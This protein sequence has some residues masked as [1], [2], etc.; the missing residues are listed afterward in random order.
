MKYA[1]VDGRR[2]EALHTGQRAACPVC[3]A[4]VIARCGARRVHHWAHQRQRDCDPWAENETPWHRAWKGHFPVEFQE[5]V[6]R[7]EQSG[8]KHIADVRNAHGLVIEF[9]RSPIAPQ[10]KVA[11][12]SFYGNMVWVVDGT[13]LKRDAPRFLRALDQLRPINDQ[14]FFLV[15]FPEECLPGAWLASSVPVFF[16]FGRVA[17]DDSGAVGFD[18]LCCL[19]PRRVGRE[20]VVVRVPRA[21]FVEVALQSAQILKGHEDFAAKVEALLQQQRRAAITRQQAPSG[22]RPHAGW[23]RRPFRRF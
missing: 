10:E 13:R 19:L 3:D 16:D 2:V 1:L 12:E 4:G 20:A 17:T 11:R 7:D 5:F 23:R 14:G 6:M 22:Q 8:E 15:P 21:Q 18:H 9:Q